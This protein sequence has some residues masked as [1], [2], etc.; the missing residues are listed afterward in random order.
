TILCYIPT[1]T[2]NSGTHTL[3]INELSAEYSN[4]QTG[5]ES[6]KIEDSEP[7]VVIYP[8]PVTDGTFT[9]KANEDIREVEI[10][11]TAGMRVLFVGG[12]NN[13]EKVNVSMLPNGIYFVKTTTNQ[14]S[15]ISKIVIK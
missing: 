2:S 3:T 6:V 9:V 8:N 15:K 10:Y 1:G 14:G 13:T 4:Y 11:N 12:N 7:Q 5:V